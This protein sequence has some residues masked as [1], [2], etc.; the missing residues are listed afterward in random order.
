MVISGPSGVGKGTVCKKVSELTG[1]RIA[2]SATSRDKRKGETE[3][4]DYY[5]IPEEEFRLR[6]ERGDFIE[7]AVVYGHYYG[8]LKS[9]IEGDD[10]VILEIDTQGAMKVLKTPI[11][12]LSIFLLPPSM[13]EL[14][15]RIVKRG[16]EPKEAIEA[17]LKAAEAEIDIGKRRYKHVV[18]ND[19]VTRAA[20]EI[21]KIIKA[22]SK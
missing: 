16:R 10:D 19:D 1:I 2:I 9:E 20:N 22:E 13:E 17:R 6:I 11:E 7:Y 21:A 5:F 8:T 18:I 15:D 14:R 12:V 3:G 4:K